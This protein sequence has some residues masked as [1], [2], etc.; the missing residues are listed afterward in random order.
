MGPVD[1]RA[2]GALAALEVGEVGYDV[3]VPGQSLVGGGTADA[4][5]TLA[6]G[7]FAALRRWVRGERRSVLD[8][9][10]A[11]PYLVQGRLARVVVVDAPAP[12]EA[13]LRLF[14]KEL[15]PSARELL[16]DLGLA[17]IRIGGARLCADASGWAERDLE[18]D[19][20][21]TAAEDFRLLA[22]YVAERVRR[23]AGVRLTTGFVVHVLK[24]K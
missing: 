1:A 24:A 6:T 15:P 8:L 2:R 22:E 7:R 19:P 4:V 23:A 20:E 14:T 18:H 5:V 12:P 11:D 21:A 13:R 16:R 17:G 10:G 9:R 3:L